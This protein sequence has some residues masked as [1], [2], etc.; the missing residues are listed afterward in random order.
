LI[1]SLGDDTIAGGGGADVLI[2]ANGNDTISVG[3][4]SFARIFG[5]GGVDTLA[6]AGSGVS[7][8]FTAVANNKIS[9]IERLDLT[10]SG[11]N[12]ATLAASDLFHFSD[13]YDR[14]FTAAAGDEALVV[15]GDSGDTL[16]LKAGPG[17]RSLIGNDV[18]L[19]GSAGGDYDIYAYSASG[20]QSGFVAVDKDVGTNLI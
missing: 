14:R 17:A 6:L 8:D 1:G 4:G 19:D 18:G 11:D 5:G 16:N 7:I 12:I 10:G 3:G 2:G 20:G 15:D 9:S 13:T